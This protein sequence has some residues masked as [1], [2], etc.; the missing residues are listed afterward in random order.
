MVRIYPALFAVLL[1]CSGEPEA[2][3]PAPK[4]DTVQIS[5]EGT[6]FEPAVSKDQLPENAWI[7]DMGSVH[8]AR[9]AEGDGQCPVC[10]MALKQHGHSAAH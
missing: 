10:G 9:S 1:A 2:P 6:R 5:P 3:A 7:C 8:Y 4:A